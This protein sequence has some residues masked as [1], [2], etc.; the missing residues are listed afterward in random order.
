M[1]EVAEKVWEAIHRID[2]ATRRDDVSNLR[3]KDLENL[4]VDTY[5][6]L[7]SIAMDINEMI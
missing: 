2:Q 3:R 5:E 1:E 6:R 4:L 7:Q